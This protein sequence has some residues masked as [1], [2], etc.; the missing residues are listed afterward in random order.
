M[1][2]DTNPVLLVTTFVVINFLQHELIIG[3]YST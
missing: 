1:L 2:V 3:L